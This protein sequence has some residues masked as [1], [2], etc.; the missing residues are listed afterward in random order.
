MYYERPSAGSDHV[1]LWSDKVGCHNTQSAIRYP[2]PD[3]V[4][5]SATFGLPAAARYTGD[6]EMMISIVSMPVHAGAG[7]RP[8]QW[9]ACPVRAELGRRM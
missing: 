4:T 2:K 7:Q 3:V 1:C 9:R 5:Q 8:F 6:D